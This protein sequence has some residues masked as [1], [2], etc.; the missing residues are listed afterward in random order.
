MCLN[1]NINLNTVEEFIAAAQFIYLFI[2][3]AGFPVG[4]RGHKKKALSFAQTVEIS[5]LLFRSYFSLWGNLLF[6]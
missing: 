2:L 3:L 1:D 5:I 6:H 4:G